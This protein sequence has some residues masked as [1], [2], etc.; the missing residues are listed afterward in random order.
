MGVGWTMFLTESTADSPLTIISFFCSNTVSCGRR[1]VT[2]H[3]TTKAKSPQKPII[4][5]NRMVNRKVVMNKNTS[6]TWLAKT[7]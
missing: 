5:E 1:L 7:R 2:E 4:F 6:N 3:P